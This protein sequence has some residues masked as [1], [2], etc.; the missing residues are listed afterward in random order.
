M[1][2]V[3]RIAAKSRVV[4]VWHRRSNHELRIG[5]RPEFSFRPSLLLKPDFQSGRNW[6]RLVAR[7]PN[8][9]LRRGESHDARGHHGGA[10]LTAGRPEKLFE[11]AEFVWDR[12]G[13]Y[14]VLRDNKTFV[15]VRR[16]RV[17]GGEHRLRLVFDWSSETRASGD[18]E[19]DRAL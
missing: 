15:M 14:A 3:H 2:A 4:G 7:W 6:A 17:G 9:V 1:A 12:P 13:N 8:A 19:V 11:S 5:L 18:G 16:S 10:G